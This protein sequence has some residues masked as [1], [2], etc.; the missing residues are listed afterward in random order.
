MAPPRTYQCEG[1]I[2]QKSPMGEAD[3]LVT[4]FTKEHGKL[5]A[6]AR[7]ARRST[8][9]MVGH[10]EPLTQIRISVAHG[11]NLDHIT[12]G[13]VIENFA[14]LKSD[15][16]AITKGQYV[17]ELVAGFASEASPNQPFYNLAVEVLQN[18][19]LHPESEWPLRFFELQLLRVSGL[20]PE[21]YQCVECRQP[22]TPGNHR[23]SPSAGGTICPNCQP[24]G[25]H[26]RPLSLRAVKV[27]RL[28][29]R[30]PLL[31]IIP[32]KVNSSSAQELKSVL[33]GTVTYWLD[34]EIRSN[35]FLEQLQR[36]SK[37]EVYT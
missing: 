28:L 34:K 2:I 20:M 6:V 24:A 32:L 23:F 26:V 31:D 16:V 12:Q 35:S 25:A 4:L 27:L 1:L 14:A 21:L 3:L 8:S 18:I 9:K 33:G 17:A 5:R 7:G 13:Q 37:S 29:H 10:L 11:R 30:G 15:L 36:E 22:L 19:G